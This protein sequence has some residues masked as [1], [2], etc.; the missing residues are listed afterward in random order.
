MTYD[1]LHIAE[2]SAC[3]RLDAIYDRDVDKAPPLDEVATEAALVV[4]HVRAADEEA[5]RAQLAELSTYPHELRRI[6]E[7]GA[8]SLDEASIADGDVVDN[9][10][11][12]NIITS[13]IVGDNF[14]AVTESHTLVVDLDV[15]A[16]LVPSSTPGHT[17]L[18]IDVPMSWAAAVKVLDALAAAGVVEDGYVKAS[19]RRGWSAARLPWVRK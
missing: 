12:A 14:A 10:T 3:D 15:P 4:Q 5:M 6:R 11:D 9:V 16:R 7:W 1:D 8:G 17:H 19:K 2:L 18:Y 13:R